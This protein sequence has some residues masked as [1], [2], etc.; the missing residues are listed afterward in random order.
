MHP[1]DCLF[2]PRSIALIGASPEKDRI[3]G[4]VFDNLRHFHGTLFPVNPHH[5]EIGGFTSYP[6]I[7]DVPEVVDLSVI[8]RPAPEV[9][10]LLREHQG[11]A[12]CALI[13]SSGFAEVGDEALQQ[14]VSADGRQLGIRLIGPNCLGVFNPYHRL[15]TFFLPHDRFKRP[16]KGNVAIVSQSGGLLICLLE[17]L[18]LVGRGVSRG[19]N[20]GNAVDIDAPDLY[21]YLA[22]DPDTEVVVSYLE[23]VGNGR[24][25]IDAARRL[26]AR[27]PLLILKAGKGQGGAN[28]GI[29]PYGTAGRPIRRVQ[30]DPAP[31][32]HPGGGG[33][34]G[35][36]RCV[37]RPVP[38][39]QRAGEKGLHHYQRRGAWGA[40]GG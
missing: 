13:V 5:N 6:S 33:F 9:H 11:K 16:Q 3:G 30:F 8:L 27:K 17:A 23:S 15:D 14:E 1:L 19:A 38:S 24:L 35:T 37:P 2:K 4:I 22:E 10:R 25:F 36:G 7:H 28:G 26:A 18:A 39:A 21:D 40:R 12:R 32:G 29:F 34:R 31:Y 20:Y